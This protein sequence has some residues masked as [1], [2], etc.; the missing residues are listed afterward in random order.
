MGPLTMTRAGALEIGAA[1]DILL[2]AQLSNARALRPSEGAH[3]AT[4]AIQRN[5]SPRPCG[6]LA[7]R[8]ST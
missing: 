1:E 2:A 5:L 7:G 3:P 4:P 8:P 6:W